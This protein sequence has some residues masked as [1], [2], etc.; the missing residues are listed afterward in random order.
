ML[1]TP[2]TK[3]LC[4]RDAHY[5]IFDSKVLR[6]KD[7]HDLDA[8]LK[9]FPDNEYLRFLLDACLVSGRFLKPAEAQYALALGYD[10]QWLEHIAYTG[11]FFV[12]KS[13]Q[14][15]V[16]WLMC[17][18][19]LWRARARPYQLLLVQSKREDDA[20]MLVFTKEPQ[21]ARISFLEYSLPKELQ[22]VDFSGRSGSYCHLHFPNGSHIW[23]IPEG[24]DIIRS[25]T[26]SALFDDEAAFQPNFAAA[27]T[28]TLPA[29]KGGGQL[30]AVS[31]AEP[32]TFQQIVES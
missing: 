9:P 13:R 31:S 3:E 7:E 5:F 22:I 20:A 2:A 4:R 28:A 1:I 26:P 25:N 27:Y 18:Y 29:I 11:L 30:I 15:M 6:T 10:R 19:F 12:E 16:T 17:A 32:G 21:V 14:L 8:P 23:G 24:G